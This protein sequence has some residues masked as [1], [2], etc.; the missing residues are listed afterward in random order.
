M[1]RQLTEVVPWWN[2]TL[3]LA[4][5]LGTKINLPFK[6]TYIGLLKI[7]KAKL[8]VERMISLSNILMG[9]LKLGYTCQLSE[10]LKA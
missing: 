7:D 8:L 3:I 5:I 4:Y 1:D 6:K 10:R 2:Y 9:L